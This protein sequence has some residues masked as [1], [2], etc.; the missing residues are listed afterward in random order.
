[1]QPFSENLSS[2]GIEL[3]RGETTTL[4]V[5]VGLLCN[6]ACK[7][8][9]LEA[10]PQRK[11][12]MSAETVGQVI[13]YAKQ[14]SFGA[15]DITGGAPELNPNTERLITHLA[16]LTGRIM[17]RS[18]LTAEEANRLMDVCREHRVV[19]IASLPALSQS[20]TDSQRGGGVFEKS[21]ASL[22]SLNAMGYGQKD[23][24]LELNLVSNPTGAYLATSQQQ[25]E[26]R[27]RDVLLKKYGIVFNNLFSF[28]NVPLGRY[29]RWLEQS[30]NLDAYQKK[31]ADSFN[32]GAVGGVM[33]RYQVSV[34]WRGYLYDCDF[35][36]ALGLDLGGKRTHVSD[37]T[38]PPEP[39][40]A[41]EVG[42]HCYA[43]T[44]GAGFT[45]GGVI[46]S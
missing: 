1:M 31:L 7:H 12:I 32:P 28:S 14:C 9:H 17:L 5:N 37:L 19:I 46:D 35:N 24:G 15:I 20:Q 22:K 43:C 42:E 3:C 8:C 44:A 34:D 27:F 30:G 25:A 21:I 11:E 10:G 39:G 36:L 23:T 6:Q 33:C 29:Q 4:Q 18:N 40:C 26:M 41:I 45:C 13:E 16:P 2:H 38:C